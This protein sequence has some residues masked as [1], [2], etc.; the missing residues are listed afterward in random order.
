M[1]YK[2]TV[3]TVISSSYPSCQIMSRKNRLI[4]YGLAI[5]MISL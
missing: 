4:P 5:K 1:N 2:N 3:V